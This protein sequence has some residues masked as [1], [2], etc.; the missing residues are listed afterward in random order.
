MRSK[1]KSLKRNP[2]SLLPQLLFLERKKMQHLLNELRF[3]TGITKTERTKVQQQNTLTPSI[4]TF[5]LNN[6]LFYLGSN[7]KLSGMGNGCRQTRNAIKMPSE[8][9][10]QNTQRFL[11]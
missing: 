6:H 11:R 1:S 5:K 7:L 9:G 4:L 8:L 2:V 10:K 3:S